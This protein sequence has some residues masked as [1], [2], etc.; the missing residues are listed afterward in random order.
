MKMCDQYDHKMDQQH[1]F[2]RRFFQNIDS[3]VS[4]LPA[5]FLDNGELLI[6]G[7]FFRNMRHEDY[8]R[9]S[10]DTRVG[11]A[12]LFAYIRRH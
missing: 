7:T 2:H 11:I 9:P 3:L 4:L 10:V 6:K 1:P 5:E 8:G 12:R